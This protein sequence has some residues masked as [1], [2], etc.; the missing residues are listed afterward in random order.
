VLVELTAPHYPVLVP[1]SQ[2]YQ[3]E[4]PSQ[5]YHILSP[6]QRLIRNDVKCHAADAVAQLAELQKRMSEEKAGGEMCAAW[7]RGDS[8]QVS[9]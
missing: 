4:P 5:S 2:R 8:R 9:G 1:R 3:H 7:T 6:R